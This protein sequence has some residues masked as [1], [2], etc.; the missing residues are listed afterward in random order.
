[1]ACAH[2]FAPL[3]IALCAL[4]GCGTIAFYEDVH[5][6]SFV[7]RS[8]VSDCALATKTA[9]PT[10]V[11]VAAPEPPEPADGWNDS[12]HD[13]IHQPPRRPSGDDPLCAGDLRALR[14]DV[15]NAI[16]LA[17]AHQDW[18]RERCLSEKAQAVEVLYRVSMGYPYV[19]QRGELMDVPAGCF[20][21]ALA[22]EA[23]TC[24]D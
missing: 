6:S 5:T 17:I 22:R 2:R 13:L 21:D 11:A 20:A 7:E 1:M 12:L 24:T 16:E 10:Q 4:P 18:R 15:S 14:T 9:P 19:D 8:G 3:A 23:Q